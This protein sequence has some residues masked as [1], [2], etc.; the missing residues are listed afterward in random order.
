M[1]IFQFTSNEEND[2]ISIIN[3]YLT[4]ISVEHMIIVS[5]HYHQQTKLMLLTKIENLPSYR[6]A[7]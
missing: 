2:T 4:I 5:S 3:T 7:A 6:F 1:T